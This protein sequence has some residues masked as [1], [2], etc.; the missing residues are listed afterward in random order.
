MTTAAS[1]FLEND[2]SFFQARNTERKQIE[3]VPTR[4]I[5]LLAATTVI[6]KVFP[7]RFQ[8]MEQM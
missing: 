4:L 1:V 8:K 7:E 3:K 5:L 6:M 2:L